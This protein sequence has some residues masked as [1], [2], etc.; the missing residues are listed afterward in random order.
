MTL[1]RYELEIQVR[2]FHVLTEQLAMSF[3]GICPNFAAIVD[4]DA[5]MFLCNVAQQRCTQNVTVYDPT[6]PYRLVRDV[7]CKASTLLR[8]S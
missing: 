7:L 2:M 6:L 4:S 5:Q 1:V 3:M 8:P